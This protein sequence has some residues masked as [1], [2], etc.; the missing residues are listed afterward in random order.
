MI[1]DKKE[2]VLAYCD[3]AA[4]AYRDCAEIMETMQKDAPEIL[5]EYFAHFSFISDVMR[6]KSQ[7]VHTEAESF[8]FGVKQ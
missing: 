7:N 5:K 2:L 6:K 1:K 3:G 4:M 8:L